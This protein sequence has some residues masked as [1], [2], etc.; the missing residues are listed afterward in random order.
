MK[1]QKEIILEITGT[2]IIMYSDFAVKDIP[3]NYDYLSNNYFEINQVLNHIYNGSIVGFS[4]GS[5]GI[6]ILN[7]KKGYPS[8]EEI[9]NYDYKIRLGIQIKDNKITFRDLFDLV[10]WEK[11]CDIEQS[12]YLEN[13]FYHI[14]ICTNIPKSTIIGD[15]QNIQIYFNSLNEMPKLKYNGIPY[16]FD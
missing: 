2:G 8:S 13:G 1:F 9:C 10:F 5:P 16:L 7:I 4:T 15:N 14:T 12:I 3:E 11:E 6:F